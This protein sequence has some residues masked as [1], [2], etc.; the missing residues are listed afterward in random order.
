MRTASSVCSSSSE[1][2]RRVAYSNE[3]GASGS[4]PSS[5]IRRSTSRPHAGW[6]S[7]PRSTSRSSCAGGRWASSSRTTSWARPRASRDDD[8]RLTESLATRAATA[9]DLSERVSRDA[10]RRVVEAQEARARSTGARAPRR[11]RASAHID[12]AGPEVARGARRDRADGGAAFAELRDLVVATLQ[13]VRR[14]A[15]ELRPAALDDFGLVPALERLRD[16][17]SEQGQ[18]AV[19]VHV[20]SRRSSALAGGDR[21]RPVSNRARGADQRR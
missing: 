8:V 4:T 10:V 15:V 20:G 13:D 11:D 2:R 16:S 12:T 3:G 5:T 7:G 18:I 19:E 17:I 14:L 6:A 1:A 9:V 21:D